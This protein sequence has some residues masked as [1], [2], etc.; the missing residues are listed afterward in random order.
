MSGRSIVGRVIIESR[1][2]QVADVLADPSY[3]MIEQAKMGGIRTVLGVPL[4]REGEQAL[5]RRSVNDSFVNLT[6]NGTLTTIAGFVVTH[7]TPAAQAILKN[8][9]VG[10][11][12]LPVRMEDLADSLTQQV[13]TL[14]ECQDAMAAEQRERLDRLDRASRR[15]RW[16]R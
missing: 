11:V 10:P 5:L 16:R 12:A 6:H 8:E 13:A 4:L 9:P 1:T 15:G 14:A 7:T 2:V 3:K